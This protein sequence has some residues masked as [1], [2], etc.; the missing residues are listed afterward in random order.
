MLGSY[1]RLFSL[2]LLVGAVSP[3]LTAHAATET[4]KVE[5]LERLI[6]NA[7]RVQLKMQKQ[8]D[9]QASDITSLR[10]QVEEYSYQIKQ[11]TERQRQLLIDLDDLR[12]STAAST[13]ASTSAAVTSEPSQSS[14]SVSASGSE[15]ADYQA[16]VDL[17]L[18]QK[19]FDG[20][21][22]AFQSFQQ[23]YPDSSYIPN[24]HYWLGQLYYS[25]NQDV[26]A[27]K[28]FAAVIAYSD[29]SKRADALVKLADIAKRNN[30]PDVA[31]KY[32]QKA[33]DEY[34]NSSSAQLAQSAL[35]NL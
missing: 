19:D 29:S 3:V 32:Y 8:L 16:A 5:Q 20:A 25:Q 21:K 7:N 27:T 14:S 30:K 23:N 12:S 9:A 6:Q 11:L 28:S 35:A 17:L 22:S 15:K 4:D 10:G 26:D 24:T 2:L 13:P 33:I 18:K 31:K 1:K 34:P